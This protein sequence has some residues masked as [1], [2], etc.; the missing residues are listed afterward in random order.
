MTQTRLYILALTLM[1][2]IYAVM[3]A[4]AW[5]SASNTADALK[6]RADEIEQAQVLLRQQ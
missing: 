2:L 1:L 5:Q 6:Q 3:G 4:I